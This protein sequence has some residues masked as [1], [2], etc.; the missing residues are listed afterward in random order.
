MQLV[1]AEKPQLG[2]VIAEAI[3]IT[4]RKDGY[5]ECKSNYVVTWGIG[6]LLAQ[7]MPQEIDPKY[8]MW[9]MEDLP[10]SFESIPLK[11]KPQVKNQFEVVERL[12]HKA[13]SVINAGDPDDEGQLLI[14]EILDY[15]QFKGKQYRILI[16][17]LNPDMAKKAL[18][19]IRPNSEFIGMKNKALARSQAD[20]LFGLN[21]TRAYTVKARSNG[22]KDVFSIGRVQTPTLGLI[23]RRYLTNKNHKQ[24]FYYL[25]NGN[26]I[27]NGKSL[28]AKLQI[29]DNIPTDPASE[30][31]KRIIDENVANNIK[32]A[33]KGAKSSI[34]SVKIE[35]KSTPPPLPFAL[36]DLQVKMN[37]LYGMS[38]DEV[39]SITQS[40]REKHKAI[41]YN[42]SDC[43]YLN[44]IQFSQAEQTLEKLCSIFPLIAKLKPDSSRKSRAFNDA[45]T[46]AHTGIIPVIGD[47]SLENM[48]NKE[49]QVFQAIA[50]QYAIQFMPNMEQQQAVALISCNEYQY[51]VSAM[52]LLNLGWNELVGNDEN[53]ID[54]EEQE[55]DISLG[56]FALI[57][58]LKENDQGDCLDVEIKKEKTKPQPIYTEATLL[59]DMQSIAKYVADPKIKTL[60]LEKDKGKVGENGGIGTPATRSAIIKNLE[61]KGYFSYQGKKLIPTEKGIDFINQLPLSIT[62]PD[63]TALWFEQQREIENGSLTVEDFL[64]GINTFISEQLE[65]VKNFK[66]ELKGE[67]CSCGQG[68]LVLK[69]FK[70]NEFFACSAYPACTISKPALNGLPAPNCPCC[71]NSVKVNDKGVFCSNEDCLKLWRKVAEK[72]LSDSQLLALLSKGKTPKIKGFKSKAGKEF[73]AV[74]K[75]NKAEKKVE[76]EFDKK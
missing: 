46:T 50:E 42:R 41:T 38:S 70:N 19:D 64:Q 65:E 36:L 58:S 63:M 51:R 12:L 17:D 39:L 24:S 32:A 69:K 1:I 15:C 53:H 44:E 55:S 34:S 59:K 23:V 56:G 22:V 43:R 11:V 27:F 3:G 52:K 72:S 5:I 31:E 47:Y 60:L 68:M 45:K 21:L 40:L 29:T 75:L 6:H 67:P 26:F 49:K 8:E 76:F 61:E 48:N 33:C 9:K 20:Y 13:E 66:V 14:D 30:K 37:N 18:S 10:F 73:E 7:K 74:L 35:D 54:D 62:T 57:Q 28:N 71:G 4:G 25:L 2:A 16:N